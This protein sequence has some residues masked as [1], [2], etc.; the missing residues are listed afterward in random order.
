M[1]SGELNFMGKTKTECQT[2]T[3]QFGTKHQRAQPFVRPAIKGAECSI[4]AAME[5]VF[6][7]KVK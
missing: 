1:P 4:K 2:G 3:K 7:E 6:N 5:R